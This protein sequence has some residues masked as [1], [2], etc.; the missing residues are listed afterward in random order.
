MA[1]FKVSSKQIIYFRRMNSVVLPSLY[2]SVSLIKLLM[3]RL[4]IL[5]PILALAACNQ[6][7]GNSSSQ[8]SLANNTNSKEYK[9]NSTPSNQQN[10]Q[11]LKTFAFRDQS[12][13]TVAE[14]PFPETWQIHTKHAQGEPSITGPNKISIVDYPLQ[15]FMYVTDPQLQQSYYQAGQ[16]MRPMPGVEQLIQQDIVPWCM[17][18][19]YS[20]VKHY[21]VP[22]ITK[23]DKWYNDQ[24][25]KAVPCQNEVMAIGTEWK[26]DDGT[27]YFLLMHLMVSTSAQMQNW[28]YWLSGLT[29]E[30]THFE[31]AKK[32][33]IFSLANVRYALEPIAAYNQREAQKAGQSWAAHNQ[34]MAQNQAAFEAQQRAFVNKSNA[35]NDAIMNG[36]RERNASSDRQHEQFVDAI[37]EKT[38]VTNTAT[39]QTYKVQSGYNQYWMNN[40]GEYISTNQYDYNPNLD[41]AMNNQQ[42]E[43]L[44]ETKY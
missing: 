31:S 1:S 21:E 5:L 12:G 40:N 8:N 7:S 24:L 38:K 15:N 35:I 30:T 19:G 26:K 44:K 20:F 22:E 11:K 32:Q 33:L 27:P 14:M 29:A 42:W 6:H 2:S 10:W 43:E 4:K 39:G 16:P 23:A 36:W 34:R 9:E 25:Y 18:N 41:D 37:T 17:R 13:N 28:S 3:M